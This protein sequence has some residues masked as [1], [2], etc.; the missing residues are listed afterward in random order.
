MW[1]TESSKLRPTPKRALLTHLPVILLLLSLTESVYFF[2]LEKD[3]SDVLRHYL[4]YPSLYSLA[5]FLHVS[6]T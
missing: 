5:S 1:E 4:L 3:I 6:V 2:H